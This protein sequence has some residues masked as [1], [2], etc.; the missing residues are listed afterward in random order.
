MSSDSNDLPLPFPPAPPGNHQ[1][2]GIKFFL[3]QRERTGVRAK[4]FDTLTMC[5][6]HPAAVEALCPVAPE[7]L[8]LGGI[9]VAR[10]VAGDST[11]L[12]IS[13]GNR[14]SVLP[15]GFPAATQLFTSPGS[16]QWRVSKMDAV[17]LPTRNLQ[18]PPIGTVAMGVVC[19][20][21]QLAMMGKP[22]NAPI[23]P[24]SAV[25][26]SRVTPPFLP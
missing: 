1:F 19:P 5:Q 22:F 7:H 24:M 26:F 10:R 21:S 16:I 6:T 15:S 18:R 4:D 25:S 17:P 3:I 23:A 14:Y 11:A 13:R 12:S 9:C 20:K 2:A 8:P